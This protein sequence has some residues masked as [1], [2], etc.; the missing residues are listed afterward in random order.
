MQ[1]VR[2]YIFSAKFEYDERKIMFGK[3]QK[4]EP[5]SFEEILIAY[6]TAEDAIRGAEYFSKKMMNLK[7]I[8]FYKI[9]LIYCETV[10][11]FKE[12][13]DESNL[14]V[15]LLLGQEDLSLHSKRCL[16][17]PI[18]KGKRNMG[19]VPGSKLRD[20]D[21]HTFVKIG[22]RMAFERVL[23]CYSE[24]RRQGQL[25]CTIGQLKMEKII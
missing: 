3:D 11:E 19:S 7:T 18:V 12:F 13:E 17:G 24:V 6:E 14:V 23:Y 16:I 22:N 1:Q 15:M 5:T 25:P 4:N 9:N 21:Y 2:G 8:E 20:N 10:Q